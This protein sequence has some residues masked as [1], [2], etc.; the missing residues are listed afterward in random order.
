LNVVV[1]DL[2]ADG[3]RDTDGLS[4][5]RVRRIGMVAEAALAA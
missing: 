1:V 5:R 4:V 3:A 2:D